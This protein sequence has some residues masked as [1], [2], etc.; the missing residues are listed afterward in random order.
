MITAVYIIIVIILAFFIL[1]LERTGKQ[2]IRLTH[3]IYEQHEW[4]EYRKEMIRI[5]Y[6]KHLWHNLTFRNPWKL[7]NWH[8]QTLITLDDACNLTTKK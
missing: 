8:I 2:R 3:L 6:D 7:Y 4:K 1:M 5:S